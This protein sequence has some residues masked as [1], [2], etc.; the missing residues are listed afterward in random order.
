MLSQRREQREPHLTHAAHERLLLHLHALMLQE[1]RGLA[2]D[3]HTLRAL[4]G[5]V[6]IHHALM[7]VRV[8]QVRYVM[9]A[10]STLVPSLAPYLQGGLLGLYGVLLAVLG[11]LQGGVRLQDDS[12]HRAAERVVG[13]L[14]ESVHDRRWSHRMLLLLLP[15]LRHP[16]TSHAGIQR[17]TKKVDVGFRLRTRNTER[18]VSLLFFFFLCTHFPR[19]KHL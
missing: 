3:L 14:G 10:G 17:E 5:P 6:L 18:S 12:V 7:L 4:E 15:R 8:R 16:S 13:P 1:V 19:D 2:E 9:T 11:L